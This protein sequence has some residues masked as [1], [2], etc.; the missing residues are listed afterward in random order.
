MDFREGCRRVEIPDGAEIVAGQGGGGCSGENRNDVV[1]GQAAAEH[2]KV[3]NLTVDG[4]GVGLARSDRRP[5]EISRQ[6]R[7][8]LPIQEQKSVNPYLF[9]G[10]VFYKNEMVPLVPP[11]V[12]PAVT[13]EGA[14]VGADARRGRRCRQPAVS[15]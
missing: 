6:G 7:R 14:D 15:K 13:G 2:G 4:A 10:L 5:V 9:V 8:A 11:C 12:V 3:I 1:A